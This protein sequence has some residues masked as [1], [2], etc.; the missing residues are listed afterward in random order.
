M[1]LKILINQISQELELTNIEFHDA[2]ASKKMP[3]ILASV[4]VCL[5]R[6]KPLFLEQFLQNYTEPWLLQNLSF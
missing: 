6:S 3:E 1:D 5:I 4:D 2:V